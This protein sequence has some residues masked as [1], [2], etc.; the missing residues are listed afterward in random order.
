MNN[1]I[2]DGIKTMG[3]LKVVKKDGEEILFDSI[4][5]MRAAKI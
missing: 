1:K 3:M 5:I 4:N 2:V